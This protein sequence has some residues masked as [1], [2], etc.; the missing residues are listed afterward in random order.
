MGLNILLLYFLVYFAD[1]G[2]LSP[3]QGSFLLRVRF[4]DPFREGIHAHY[5]EELQPCFGEELQPCF[6]EDL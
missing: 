6:G 3:I 2:I 1:K 5:G 4:H